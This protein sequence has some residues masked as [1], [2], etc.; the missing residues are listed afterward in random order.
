MALA[1]AL[2]AAACSAGDRQ[3]QPAPTSPTKTPAETSTTVARFRPR[4]QLATGPFP[5]QPAGV[6]WPTRE[7]PVADPP[8]E[9]DR[10]ALRAVLDRAFGEL[11]SEEFNLTDAVVVVWRGRIVVERYRPGFGDAD[12]PHRSWSMAKSIVH[13]LVG[14]LVRQGRL[15]IYA[16][17]PVPEWSDPDDPRHEITVDMLLRM[18]SG[19]AW[20][21]DYFAPDSDTIA[22]LGG[23]GSKDMA[24]YAA[25]KPLEVEP[26]TRVRYSTGTTNIISG[27]IGRIVGRGKDYERFVEEEL[28]E[29][30]GIDIRRTVIGWDAAGNLVGGSRFD[31][32]ARD[33]AR[34]GL[35]YARDG[36]WD[37]RRILPEGWVDYARTPTPAP[38]GTEGY[39]AHWWIYEDCEGGFEAGGF[40]GQHITV[41]PTLDLVVVLLSHRVDGRDGEIRDSLVRLFSRV[42]P[43]VSEGSS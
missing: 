30:L 31:M 39:G 16:P 26:D 20:K 28:L 18:A 7:W 27:V 17:A 11:S 22:M 21:E 33:F 37:E 35:L 34:F 24:H 4:G 10:A 8:P 6:P 41:C 1:V 42:P 38:A 3:T 43:A 23:V 36:I 25:D 12:T 15:D 5:D 9:V 19:L 40:N 2:I 32:T 14:I 29:P 13:A